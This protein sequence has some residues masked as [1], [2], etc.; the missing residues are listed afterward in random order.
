MIVYGPVPSRRLGQSV[1]INNIPLKLLKTYLERKLSVSQ[2]MKK[3]KD[4]S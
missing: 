2:E 1:G 4:F 3:K